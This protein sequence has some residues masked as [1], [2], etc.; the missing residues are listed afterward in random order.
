MR[1]GKKKKKKD[2]G[3]LR[4]PRGAAPGACGGRTMKPRMMAAMRIAECFIFLY[5]LCAWCN[6]SRDR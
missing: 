2:E 4:R 3:Q 6:Q 1:E 5:C